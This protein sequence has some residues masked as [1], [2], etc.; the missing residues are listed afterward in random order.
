M[1]PD[2]GAPSTGRHRRARTKARRRHCR[3]LCVSNGQERRR[4]RRGVGRPRTG[5]VCVS[6]DLSRARNA[7]DVYVR[8]LSQRQAVPGTYR[9][10]LRESCRHHSA[11]CASIRR[12]WK[13][14]RH[15]DGEAR[16]IAP[17][18]RSGRPAGCALRVRH[19][20]RLG[21]R[22]P[23]RPCVRGCRSFGVRGDVSTTISS[24]DSRSGGEPLFLSARRSHWLS[25]AGRTPVRRAGPES[26]AAA[27]LQ[28]SLVDAADVSTRSSACGAPSGQ[29]GRARVPGGLRLHLLPVR[30]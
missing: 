11:R 19:A 5:G 21:F 29:D 27:V 18:G 15:T 3:G 13:Y 26:V 22:V 4:V 16:T 8:R 14:V 23:C 25:D 20:L 24:T 7:C 28:Q 6:A 1:W 17:G 30:P 9:S 2:C 12:V 10:I